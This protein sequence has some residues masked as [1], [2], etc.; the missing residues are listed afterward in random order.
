MTGQPKVTYSYSRL[1]FHR[2][3]IE[4]LQKDDVF[5]IETPA[6]VF[7]LSKGDFYQTFPNVAL[8]ANIYET[9]STQ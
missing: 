9:L 4:P 1:T 5:R 8:C 3:S 6:G 7:E 2:D